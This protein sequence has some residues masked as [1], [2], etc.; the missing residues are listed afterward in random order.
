MILAPTRLSFLC[1]P[2]S[3]GFLNGIL[4]NTL[5]VVVLSL[6]SKTSTLCTHHLARPEA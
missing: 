5:I 6:T 3:I 4:D 2:A 1:V